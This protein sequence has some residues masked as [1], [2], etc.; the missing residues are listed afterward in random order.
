[1]PRVAIEVMQAP[2]DPR[3]IG[4]KILDHDER[5]P[6]R[7]VPPAL[8]PPEEGGDEFPRTAELRPLW[9]R[10]HRPHHRL[11]ERPLGGKVVVESGI[12]DPASMGYL[13]QGRRRVA[14]CGEQLAG[15]LEHAR[16]GVAASP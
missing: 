13:A 2:L 8:P 4:I 6:V 12:G 15:G 9:W 5:D 3:G 11:V 10:R 7:V 14:T 16:P 1:P